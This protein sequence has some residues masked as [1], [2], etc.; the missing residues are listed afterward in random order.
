[1]PDVHSLGIGRHLDSRCEAQCGADQVETSSSSY[2]HRALPRSLMTFVQALMDSGHAPKVASGRSLQVIQ[3]PSTHSTDYWVTE[4]Q[5]CVCIL[6]RLA[7]SYI[8]RG[9]IR[10]RIVLSSVHAGKVRRIPYPHPD[11]QRTSLSRVSDPYSNLRCRF[12]VQ[13]PK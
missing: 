4:P 1:M 3:T 9:H 2:R 10:P 6:D 11:R 7:K 12:L 8:R 5:N 13:T